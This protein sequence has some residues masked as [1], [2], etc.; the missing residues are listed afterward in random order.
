MTVMRK[1]ASVIVWCTLLLFLAGAMTA[2]ASTPAVVTVS[3]E[4]ASSGEAIAL[5]IDVSDNPGM[6]AWMFDLSWDPTALSLNMEGGKP[7]EAGDPFAPGTLLF[8][9]LDGGVRVSWFNTQNVVQSGTLFTLFLRVSPE[10]SGTYPVKIQCSDVNT[11]NADEALVEVDT[12]DGSVTVNSSGGSGGPASSPSSS[13]S[14][15]LSPPD[16]EAKAESPEDKTV[17][18]FTDVTAGSYYADAVQWAIENGITSGI[19]STTFSPDAPCT[20]AQTVTFLWRAAGSPEPTAQANPFTDVKSDAYY[21]EAVLWAVEQGITN[22]TTATTFSPDSTVTRGQVVTLLFRA[23]GAKKADGANPFTDVKSGEYYTDAVLWAVA[24]GITNGT[25]ATTFSPGQ[26]C[27]R[28]QIV[29]FLYR[30]K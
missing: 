29:T 28:G 4:T 5:T 20:R 9:Q 2:Y 14:S 11:I 21:Y 24:K 7:V 18:S 13:P 27:T 30:A 22:G 17:I 16:G 12:R 6:A 3:S 10:A 26:N 19:T 25:T 1:C 8:K 15:K 23:A